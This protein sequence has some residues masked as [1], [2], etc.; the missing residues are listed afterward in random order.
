MRTIPFSTSK[1]CRAAWLTIGIIPFGSLM[2]RPIIRSSVLLRYR[3]ARSEHR[4][5]FAV[6]ARPM[7]SNSLTKSKSEH[8]ALGSFRRQSPLVRTRDRVRPHGPY[9]RS[10][11]SP[12]DRSR[13]RFRGYRLGLGC[14]TMVMPQARTESANRVMRR[15]KQPRILI[16]RRGPSSAG[17]HSPRRDGVLH[18]DDRAY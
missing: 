18:N 17:T 11:T 8:R 16:A 2:E 4:S 5:F 15:T 13:S 1:C 3:T 7:V 12:L 9:G 10:R 14:E 6:A